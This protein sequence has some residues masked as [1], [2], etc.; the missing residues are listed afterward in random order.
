MGTTACRCLARRRRWT[1]AAIAAAV[2]LSGNRDDELDVG[3]NL[4]ADIRAV[5][6]SVPTRE[7]LSTM[8]LLLELL[9]I[10]ES[11]WRDWWSDPR[12]DELRISKAAPRKLA[13]ALKPFGIRRTTV[14]MPGGST[15]KGYRLDDFRDAWA[16][17]LPSTHGEEGSGGEEPSPMRPR[18]LPT[19]TRK[20]QVGR[21]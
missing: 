14:W 10:E 20:G 11:P 6:D 9:Q 3:V 21:R 19:R 5:F 13:Q 1:E 8:E 2:H 12:S 17:Y 18:A 7:A 4:L 15:A 16:R